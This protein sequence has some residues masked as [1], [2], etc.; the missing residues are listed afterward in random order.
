ARTP[1]RTT[2]PV[3]PTPPTQRPPGPTLDAALPIATPRLALCR[4]VLSLPG[5][6]SDSREFH[7]QGDWIDSRDAG[8]SAVSLAALAGQPS[9]SRRGSRTGDLLVPNQARYQAVLRTTWH[10]AARW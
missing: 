3:A 10:Y 1:P 8:I 5:P 7:R 4:E 2:T 9:L 6:E